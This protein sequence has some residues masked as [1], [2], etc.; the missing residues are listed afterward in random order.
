MTKYTKE[1]ILNNEIIIRENEDGSISSFM[2]DPANADYQAYL[3][4]IDADVK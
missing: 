2:T 4:S 3:E 1:T